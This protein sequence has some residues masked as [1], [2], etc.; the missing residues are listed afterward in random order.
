MGGN[1]ASRENKKIKIF[2]ILII[3]SLFLA[4]FVTIFIIFKPNIPTHISFWNDNYCYRLVAYNLAKYSKLEDSY[5]FSQSVIYGKFPSAGYHSTLFSFIL[6]LILKVFN[7][8]K[9]A[10]FLFNYFLTATMFSTMY[11]YSKRE[12]REKQLLLFI[13]ILATF[14]VIIIFS[15]VIMM[16]IFFIS[17]VPF[18]YY[19]FLKLPNMQFNVYHFIILLILSLII[20]ARY[21]Y[22]IIAFFM[23]FI[24]YKK[25]IKNKNILR[26]FLSI[27]IFGALLFIFIKI[28][29]SNLAYYPI[30]SKSNTYYYI[31][32]YGIKSIF[33][34]E[35]WFVL[36]T[37]AFKQ[38]NI[39]INILKNPLSP[40]GSLHWLLFFL[41]IFNLIFMI[42]SK[43]SK[44][45]KELFLIL[46]PEFIILISSILFYS[47]TFIRQLRPIFG[48]IPLNILY[49]FV[50][51]KKLKIK[52][53]SVIILISIPLLIFTSFNWCKTLYIDK[54]F[55]SPKQIKSAQWISDIINTY[56]N[57]NRY[58]IASG[59]NQM[60]DVIYEYNIDDICI[61]MNH[62][63]LPEEDFSKL[64]QKNYIDIWII[65]KSS[66][67][68]KN[69]LL[70]YL[71][72]SR[73]FV[74]L[75]DYKN[76]NTIIYLKN[77]NETAKY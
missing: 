39:F 16:E 40:E 47:V 68:T 35:F 20:T 21:T 31:V 32:H 59:F 37:N 7:N 41:L 42:R 69:G 28:F 4:Y 76:Q 43:N 29:N 3:I 63:E 48:F 60:W 1:L 33:T 77:N 34:R 58:I 5:F 53:Q 22:A 11:F 61:S 55:N 19:I 27:I 64:S 71:D 26:I 12:L 8:S 44:I 25:W 57:K 65:D 23:L 66:Y 56:K 49:T 14:P 13:V 75:N 52:R 36:I 72:N 73:I 74:R 15:N 50:Y 2:K 54:N 10:Y 17:M 18:V 45:K 70:K 38:I 24:T 6:G 51:L 30:Y 62:F 67:I 9:S 46:T